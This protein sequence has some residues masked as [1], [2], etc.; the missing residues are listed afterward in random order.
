M[1]LVAEGTY[2]RNTTAV[3]TALLTIRNAK[4]Q[5]VGMIGTYMAC[6]E[7]IRLARRIQLHQ[8]VSSSDPCEPKRS[9]AAVPG[10]PAC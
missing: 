5:A 6:A 7:F 10:L 4:P 1:K 9:G 8:P 3:K 2:M